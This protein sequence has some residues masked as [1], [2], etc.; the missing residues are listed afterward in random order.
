MTTVDF[1]SRP[2][3]P[4]TSAPCS[5]GEVRYAKD[6]FEGLALMEPLVRIA[7]GEARNAVGLPPLN[8]A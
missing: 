1:T 3:M 6:A 7:R 2:L 8:A 5:D 4:M